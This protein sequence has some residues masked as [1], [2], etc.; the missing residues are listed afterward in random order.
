MFDDG[1]FLPIGHRGIVSAKFFWN[2]N[3]SAGPT[4]DESF[5]GQAYS[6]WTS[7]TLAN[8][9]CTRL[10]NQVLQRVPRAGGFKDFLVYA[11]VSE[12]PFR[13]SHETPHIGSV[14][15]GESIWKGLV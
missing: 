4:Y 3:K 6:M 15:S 12:E 8:L 13:W 9:F 10:H 7:S 1:W 5:S 2:V 14:K 11:R